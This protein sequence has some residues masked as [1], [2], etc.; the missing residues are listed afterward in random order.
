MTVD[1]EAAAW[2]RALLGARSTDDAV[3][4]LVADGWTRQRD[5]VASPSGR[6]RAEDRHIAVLLVSIERSRKKDAKKD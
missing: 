3:A 5:A 6:Y 1:T 2:W 4:R